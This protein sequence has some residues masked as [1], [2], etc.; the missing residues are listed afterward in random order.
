MTV[1]DRI[2]EHLKSHGEGVD[3]DMLSQ[4]L[5]LTRRQH[6]NQECRKLESVGLV[7]RRRVN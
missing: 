3:D 1:R 7:E 5:G 2:I 4:A 6:A